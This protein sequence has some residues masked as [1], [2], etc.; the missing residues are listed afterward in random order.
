[1]FVPYYGTHA[2]QSCVTCKERRIIVIIY[3]NTEIINYANASKCP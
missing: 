2:F 1:M 3:A